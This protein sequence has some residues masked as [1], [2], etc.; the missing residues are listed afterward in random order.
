MFAMRQSIIAF[1]PLAIMFGS[2]RAQPPQEPPLPPWADPQAMFEQIFGK[3]GEVDEQVL[4]KIQVSPKEERQIGAQAVEA[5][6]A[7]IKRQGMRVVVR[8]KDVD[9]LRDLVEK[10]HPL[11]ENRE[12]YPTIKIY[13]V[14][15]SRCDARSFPGGYLVFFSGLLDFA[16]NEA[17]LIGIV[18]HELSHF[19]RGHHTR[20]IKQMKL[21]EHAFSGRGGPTSMQQFF[22]TGSVMMRTWMRPFRVEYER[23]ADYDGARWSYLADYDCREM[24]RLFLELARRRNNPQFPIPDFFRSHP[25]QMERYR[26]IMQQYQE[27]QAQLPKDEL[28][29]GMENLRRR[30][31]CGK[32]AAEN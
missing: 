26:A 19:S 21:P 28:H 3:E 10:L 17:A 12:R 24:A 6:L 31:A 18:G 20:R 32:H 1:V 27:L 22:A 30:T 2:A 5:Y 9:Y 7:E 8:G 29:V 16:E 23:E 13:L 15:S 4:A 25:P 11:M 14:T